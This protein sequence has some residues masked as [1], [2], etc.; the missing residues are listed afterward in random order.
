M[1]GAPHEPW[2]VHGVRSLYRSPWVDLELVDVDS[3]A[4][5]FEHHVV[6]L[7]PSVGTLVVV[8]DHVL[9]IWRHRLVTDSWSWEL[10]GGWV[11]AGETPAAAA[12]RETEEETGWRP[13]GLRHL[14][15]LEPIAG[16]VDAV[17]HVFVAREAVRRG[18]PTD[19]DEQGEVAWVPV[20]ELAG[21]LGSARIVGGVSVTAVL[22]L[23][24]E[25]RGEGTGS[26]AA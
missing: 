7:S 6:R 8:D 4:R 14:V 12:A 21:L 17:Q 5:R 20:D 24:A 18:F 25:L 26:A 19:P 22:W 10:P 15:G 9:M 11:D 23:L 2:R 16:I 13:S 3:G 1:D